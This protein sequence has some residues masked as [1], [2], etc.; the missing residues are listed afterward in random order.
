MLSPGRWLLAG[1]MTQALLG[2]HLP[3]DQSALLDLLPNSIELLFTFLLLTFPM[4]SRTHLHQGYS[5]RKAA[6]RSYGAARPMSGCGSFASVRHSAPSPQL[7]T[8]ARA[9]VCR[10]GCRVKASAKTPAARAVMVVAG[11]R[12]DR[13]RSRLS[14]G[15][16]E[17]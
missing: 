14:P 6:A 12:G 3:D 17:R 5:R 1:R 4:C 16:H 7:G 8:Q 11:V 13:V 9:A 10:G 15:G 2:R